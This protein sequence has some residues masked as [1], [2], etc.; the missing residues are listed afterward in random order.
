MP[1]GRTRAVSLGTEG[2]P[3]TQQARRCQPQR[4]VTGSIDRRAE[5]RWVALLVAAIGEHAGKPRVARL[6]L[7]PPALV[8]LCSGQW[9]V[10]L[11]A[12]PTRSCARRSERRPEKRRTQRRV[13]GSLGCRVVEGTAERPR[14]VCGK[15]HVENGR[16]HARQWGVHFVVRERRGE[17]IEHVV[18]RIV[19]DVAIHQR[20]EVGI[21]GR[22][23][24]PRRDVAD[25]LH[26]PHAHRSCGCVRQRPLA[27]APDAPL[28]ALPGGAGRPAATA[29]PV[30]VGLLA[31]RGARRDAVALAASPRFGHGAE[32]RVREGLLQRWAAH[33]AGVRCLLSARRVAAVARRPHDQ[34]APTTGHRHA[35]ARH[36]NELEMRAPSS[37]SE[38]RRVGHTA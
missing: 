25:H 29:S 32:Y 21:D 20:P 22:D 13:E 37:P 35:L 16:G 18:A 17:R 9:N 24:S 2:Q 15:P 38:V 11:K 5:A 36:E 19:R 10:Q 14:G 30:G 7:L 23:D 28:G 12:A 8:L 31:H 4:G 27:L 26:A 34:D 1:R 6:L 33:R 3:A